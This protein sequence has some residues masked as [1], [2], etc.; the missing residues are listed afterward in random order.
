MKKKNNAVITR[1]PNWPGGP[2]DICLPSP[3]KPPFWK[4]LSFQSK[5]NRRASR[6]SLTNIKP[7]QTSLTGPPNWPAQLGA[8]EVIHPS[9]PQRKPSSQLIQVTLSHLSHLPL[10]FLLL[11][12]A[13]FTLL[14]LTFPLP[15]L[16]SLTF[17]PFS[18]IRRS[19]FHP[20]P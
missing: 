20:P 18:L 15:N 6:S 13:P 4:Q 12:F 3:L 5:H 2:E 16:L 11:T 14:S 17:L 9:R 7:D 8:S 10:T 1:P 19:L